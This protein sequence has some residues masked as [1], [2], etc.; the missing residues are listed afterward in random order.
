M[1]NAPRDFPFPHFV[2]VLFWLTLWQ[3]S[4]NYMG[5]ILKSLVLCID[6]YVR[7]RWVLRRYKKPSN[8]R[9]S[10]LYHR[11]EMQMI[12]KA[13]GNQTSIT[14]YRCRGYKI[15]YTEQPLLAE[16]LQWL[17]VLFPFSLCVL[18]TFQESDISEL[19]RQRNNLWC[20]TDK[21]FHLTTVLIGRP[22]LIRT[23]LFKCHPGGK[24]KPKQTINTGYLISLHLVSVLC[25]TKKS[26]T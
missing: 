18:F 5:R 7:E 20:R 3:G 8:Q 16:P 15:G 24:K 17:P 10:L 13:E 14:F 23:M 25:I 21:D 26:S 4:M 22:H 9:G 1:V 11:A 19:Q 12:C 6:I 2:R